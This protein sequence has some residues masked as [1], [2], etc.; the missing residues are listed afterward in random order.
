MHN[1]IKHLRHWYYGLNVDPTLE[2]A[3]LG[4]LVVAI[5]SAG[6]VGTIVQ[7][8]GS[9]VPPNPIHRVAPTGTPFPVLN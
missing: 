9:L 2:R 5:L 8:R 1:Q 3:I 4:L 7:I 6:I